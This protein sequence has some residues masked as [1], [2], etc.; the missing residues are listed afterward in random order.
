MERG[1]RSLFIAV[2][3]TLKFEIPAVPHIKIISGKMPSASNLLV[4]LK[5]G[6]RITV[7]DT[8]FKNTFI[9][10]KAMGNEDTTS[11]FLS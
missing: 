7:I 6:F 5:I 8:H 11:K 10:S 2:N 1:H 3:A 9:P 4:Y